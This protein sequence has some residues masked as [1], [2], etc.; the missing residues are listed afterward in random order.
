VKEKKKIEGEK[1]RTRRKKL[2]EELHGKQKLDE[3][4]E[5]SWKAPASNGK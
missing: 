1:M 4:M 2:R 3:G 5:A